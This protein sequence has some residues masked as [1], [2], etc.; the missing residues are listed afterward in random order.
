MWKPQAAV[1]PVSEALRRALAAFEDEVSKPSEDVDLTRAAALLALHADPLID[2]EEK[3]FK[4]LRHLG[5][6][7]F[8][9]RRR[10]LDRLRSEKTYEQTMKM[11]ENQ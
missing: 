8:R 7:R 3:V 9:H 11:N 1:D 6:A 4:P 5:E 2:L 10:L